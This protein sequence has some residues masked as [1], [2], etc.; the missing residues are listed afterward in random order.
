MGSTSEQFDG[1]KSTMPARRR[2]V[3]PVVH[4]NDAYQLVPDPDASGSHSTSHPIGGAAR[5]AT[6]LEDVR[7][8][9]AEAVV[10]TTSLQ[11]MGSSDEEDIEIL[12]RV[13][14]FQ[15]DSMDTSASPNASPKSTRAR[16]VR[17]NG[18]VNLFPDGLTIELA[19]RAGCQV[20]GPAL[21]SPALNGDVSA[22][23]E[24]G[25]GIGTCET[26]TLEPLVLFG[27][28]ALS[29]SS[30]TNTYCFDCSTQA[31]TDSTSNNKC[32]VQCLRIGLIG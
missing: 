20:D 10:Q 16:A 2:V 25:A 4:F 11:S 8:H 19:T 17:K 3:L 24:D 5:F 14:N 12:D 7:R 21:Q 1:L 30:G 29:P 22:N 28:G 23:I 32:T 31:N 18:H 26:I 13:A 9:A 15:M 6:A 27:G